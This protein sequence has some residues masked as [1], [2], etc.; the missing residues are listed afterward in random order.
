MKKKLILGQKYHFEQAGH[1]EKAA[2]GIKNTYPEWAVTMCFYAALH[3]VEYY[4]KKSGYS[5]ETE[6]VGN[7]PH[8]RRRDYIR[9]LNDQLTNQN[10]NLKK[11]YT[12]LEQESKKAPYIKGLHQTKTSHD[13]YFKNRDNVDL[14]FEKLQIIKKILS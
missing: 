8:D 7:S 3:W 12:W 14:A 11:S 6:S 2:K 10:N 4:A 5:I 9:D 1:N 13:Y